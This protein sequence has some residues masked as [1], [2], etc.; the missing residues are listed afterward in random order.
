MYQRIE[1][2]STAKLLLNNTYVSKNWKLFNKTNSN[3]SLTLLKPLFS[4]KFFPILLWVIQFRPLVPQISFF[5]QSLHIISFWYYKQYSTFFL[6]TI[7]STTVRYAS[8]SLNFT[9]SKNEKVEHHIKKNTHKP[10]ILRF[11]VEDGIIL[12]CVG[13]GSNSSLCLSSQQP[14]INFSL[15]ISLISYKCLNSN[16]T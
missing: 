14:S 10:N 5:K 6:S 8:M 3:S 11:W 7:Y 1:N 9:L 15:P 12:L 13:S 16:T 4:L 2:F